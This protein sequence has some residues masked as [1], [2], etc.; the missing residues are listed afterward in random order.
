MRCIWRSHPG[1][2]GESC[3]F[4]QFFF[5][6]ESELNSV[7]ADV[8]S[9]IFNAFVNLSSFFW[10]Y[11]Y[12]CIYEF[13]TFPFKLLTAKTLKATNLESTSRC[14]GTKANWP[15]WS[16]EYNT[17]F[18][19]LEASKKYLHPPRKESALAGNWAPPKKKKSPQGG[20]M[21]SK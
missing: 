9:N 15:I 6:S 2:K 4:W 17:C 1:S 19:K 5:E 16:I 12:F 11:H 10:S 14:I 7:I 3:N 20:T 8:L 21:R 18:F 13:L